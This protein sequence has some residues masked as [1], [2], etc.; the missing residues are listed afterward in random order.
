MTLVEPYS[1]N[2]TYDD[3]THASLATRERPK[4]IFD[5]NSKDPSYGHAYLCTIMWTLHQ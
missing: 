2:V 1:Y 3:G 5:P 4:F